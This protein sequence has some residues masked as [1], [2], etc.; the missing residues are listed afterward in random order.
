MNKPV[1]ILIHGAWH[2]ARCWQLLAPLLEQAGHQVIAADLPGHG[3]S[4]LPAMR[5]TMKTYTDSVRTLLDG[6][7]EP[8][9]L[10]GHSM[11]GM[12]ITA[13][14]ACMP[15]KI[16]KLVYLCA[17][18][19]QSGDSVFSLIAR[20]RGH[21]P[22]CPIELALTM[23]DDKRTCT[24]DPDSIIPLFYPATPAA[25]A[26][27]ALQQFGIQGSLPLAAEVKFE[28]SRLQGL[29]RHYILC[30]KDKVIPL[31]HQLRMLSAQPDCQTSEL[32]AD[33][34]PFYSMPAELAARLLTLA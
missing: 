4:P 29:D 31:H 13:V 20:N 12:I 15:E 14:A 30:S 7:S 19:P 16:H 18:L 3:Q 33:H 25:L 22:L 27:Q 8:A 17:Y 23:S 9:I 24:I 1:F 28:Q 32:C 6:C 11:A 10:L 21:E 34:S 5:S 26:R 2:D